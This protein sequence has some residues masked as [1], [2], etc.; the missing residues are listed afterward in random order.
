MLISTGALVTL[1]L[2][3]AVAAGPIYELSTEAAIGLFD[4]ARYVAT[5]VPR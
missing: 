5:V 2:L 3:I 1:S 4:P